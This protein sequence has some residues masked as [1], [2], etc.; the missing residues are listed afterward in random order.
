MMRE[1]LAISWLCVSVVA[2]TVYSGSGRFSGYAAFAGYGGGAPLTYSARTDN[3]ELG[4][5]SL[6]GTGSGRGPALTFLGH[7]SD[8]APSM[9]GLAGVKTCITDPDFGAKICRVTDY[10][11]S[12]T[13]LGL[14]FNLGSNGEPNRWSS[15]AKKLLVNSTG[16]QFALLKFSADASMTA[17]PSGLYGNSDF[18]GGSYAFSETEPNVL[19]EFMQDSENGAYVNQIN[20]LILNDSD[21]NPANWTLTRTKLF[22]FNCE[23]GSCPASSA[24][25]NF[26][27]GYN[28]GSSSPHCLL[29]NWR[30]NWVGLFTPSRDDQ[31]FTVAL[32]DDGQGGKPDAT[33]AGAVYFVNYTVG[34]GCRLLNTLTDQITGDYGPT[35]TVLN[36]QA[37]NAPLTD[38]FGLH[39]G[40]SLPDAQWAVYVPWN[41]PN[42]TVTNVTADGLGRTTITTSNPTQFAVGEW[43]NFYNLSG[44]TWL[45]SGTWA[46]TTASSG[47][48][49]SIADS[50]A[51]Y[52][53]ADS[54]TVA[55][56]GQCTNS[57]KSTYCNAY[58]WHVADNVVEPCTPASCQGHAAHGFVNDYRAKYYTAHSYANPTLPGESAQL[59]WVAIPVDQ[60]GSYHN[61]GTGDQ[62]PVFLVTTNVCGQAPG[63][64]GSEACDPAYTAAYYDEIIAGENFIANASARH[65]D[66]GSGATGC[67]YRFAHTFNTGTNW[68]FNTQNAVGSVSPDGRF[69]AWAS[70]WN[71]TLGCMDGSTSCLSAY[72]ASG[73]PDATITQAQV[74]GSNHTTI[75]AAN[76]FVVGEQV[77]LKNLAAATWLNN[78]VLT[79]TSASS[80]AFAGTGV[81]HA[82][83]GPAADSGTASAVDCKNAA[84]GSLACQ[85][86]DVF[87]VDLMSAHP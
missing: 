83:Y 12:F 1:L 87:V 58:Y 25:Q 47:T 62:T 10:S 63:N 26:S 71:A 75:T 53:A 77:S 5:E 15:D 51:A 16:G 9:G 23:G 2:Q 54:G 80:S 22:N 13:P 32:S 52:S 18:P 35:G 70:D 68:N 59:F 85:R 20:Q 57:G 29:A 67:M 3:C 39:E 46:V 40:Q 49:F 33:H 60:H 31:S 64:S 37:G 65:C 86:G 21:P 38:N 66:Y 44:A 41:S 28:L 78:Q 84:A 34:K 8:V 24:T 72:I 17:T 74:D 11:A 79:I 48:S 81:A 30:S 56:A 42:G 7:S 36:G 73:P 55:P 69:L 82:A 50:H 43:V 45:N 19:Y 4:E 27:D 14:S 6:C 61:A 76:Q